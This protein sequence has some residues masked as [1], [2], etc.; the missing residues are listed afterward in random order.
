MDSNS[1]RWWV[2]SWLTSPSQGQLA[3]RSKSSLQH[4]SLRRGKDA[5][6]RLVDQACCDRLCW[7]RAWLIP[8]AYLITLML[9]EKRL[10]NELERVKRMIGDKEAHKSSK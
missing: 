5:V 9:R 1:R 7:L 2:K 6:V 8:A 3:I 10:Q 4:V